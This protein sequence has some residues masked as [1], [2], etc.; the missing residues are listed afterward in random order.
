LK[1]LTFRRL[2]CSDVMVKNVAYKGEVEKNACYIRLKSEESNL[3]R[4]MVKGN[5]YN[6]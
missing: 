1:D 3:I 4:N 6:E 2:V 5:F